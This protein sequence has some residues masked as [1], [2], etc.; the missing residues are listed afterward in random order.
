MRLKLLYWSG[1]TVCFYKGGTS[2]IFSRRGFGFKKK[3]LKVLPT[4]FFKIDP[5]VFLSS[6]KSLERPHF[7]QISEK[8]S[9]PQK[10]FLSTFLK[11]LTKTWRFFLAHAP[12]KLVYIGAAG[13]FN[14][15]LG[16]V[17]ENG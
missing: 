4:T 3:N 6:L 15:Y 1:P 5:I 7:E 17:A 11:L 16:S 10:K 14:K 13:A 9:R 12:S 8:K 2:R